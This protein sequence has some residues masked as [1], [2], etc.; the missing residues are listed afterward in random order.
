MSEP[1]DIKCVEV[2]ELI[3]DYLEDALDP[4][5]RARVEAHLAGCDN[6]STVLDQFR[7]T[8]RL[9]GMLTEDQLTSEQRSTLVSAF[10]NWRASGAAP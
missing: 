1:D 7:E 4:D 2:V 5:L 10:R 6:C 8:I 9:S 3:S